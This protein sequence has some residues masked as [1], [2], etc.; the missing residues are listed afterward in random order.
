M[1]RRYARPGR[2]IDYKAWAFIP[3]FT[4]NVSADGTVSGASL[5]FTAPATILRIRGFV[6]ANFD[7]NVQL[8]DNIRITWGIGVISSDAF[9]AGAASMPDPGGEAEYPWLWWGSMRLRSEVTSQVEPWGISAQRL[10]VD[11]KAMR[12]MKP[13]QSLVMIAEVANAAGAPATD[14]DFGQTRVLIG[15]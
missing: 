9:T 15:T 10:E 6:Q 4:T 7:S 1:P 3:A 5:A 11:T 13:G 12:K 8:G 2:T 14:L